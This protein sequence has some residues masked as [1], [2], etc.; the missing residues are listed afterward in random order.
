[1]A[2][3]GKARPATRPSSALTEPTGELATVPPSSTT[4]YQRPPPAQTP[5]ARPAAPAARRSGRWR[6]AIRSRTAGAAPVVHES[7][8]FLLALLF[9][10]WVA[11][12]FLQGGPAAVKDVIRAKFVNKGPDGSWLP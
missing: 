4:T 1:M 10:G 7:A 9:W 6:N 2:A 5:P 12:P 8:G 3:V 11:L